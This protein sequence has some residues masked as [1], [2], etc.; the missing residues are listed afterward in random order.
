M[1]IDRFVKRIGISFSYEIRY[2]R[3]S[4]YYLLLLSP[5]QI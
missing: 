2:I 3:I 1:P 5:Q 4:Y